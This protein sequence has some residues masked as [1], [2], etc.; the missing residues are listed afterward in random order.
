MVFLSAQ[1]VQC[2]HTL[3]LL[4]KPVNF[5]PNEF[6]KQQGRKEHIRIHFVK[7][8]VC[9]LNKAWEG[10]L[11]VIIMWVRSIVSETIKD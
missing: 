7:R 1:K 11:G 9:K 2:E 8:I 3:L 5:L 4:C 6:P 10:Y